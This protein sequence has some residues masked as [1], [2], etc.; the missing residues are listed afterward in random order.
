M[1]T[2]E[3]EEFG[4]AYD[5]RV[6]EPAQDL[7]LNMLHLHGSDVMF[8]QFVD[9]PVAV[10]N[11]HDRDTA[12]SLKEAHDLFPG[13]LCGGLQREKTMVLGSPDQVMAEARDA[14]AATGGRRFILGTGCVLPIIA[15]RA[16][17]MAARKSVEG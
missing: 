13:V 3:Y 9:Y 5:L 2:A 16:N 10:I 11:W 7:W 15:P 1:S 6:L 12:P 8:D 4:R 17:L 14:L